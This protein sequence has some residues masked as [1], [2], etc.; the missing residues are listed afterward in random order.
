MVEQPVPKPSDGEILVRLGCCGLCGTDLE[1]IQGSYTASMPI[2]GHEAVGTV[3]ECG[4][5]VTAV[6]VGDRV[7]PHH[8]VPCYECRNCRA[9]STTTCS[10]YRKSNIYP[11]GFSEYFIVPRWNIEHGGLITLPEHVDFESASFIEPLGCVVRSLK[12]TQLHGDED[13]LI[14]GAGPMGL[15]HAQLIKASTHCSVSVY[16]TSTFRSSYSESLGIT[17]AKPNDGAVYD[18][19]VVATGN[20]SAIAYALRKVRRGGKVTVFGVPYKGSALDYDLADLLNNELTLLTSN[21]ADDDDTRTAAKLIS[22]GEIH[23]ERLV[24]HRFSIDNIS[25]AVNTA[26]KAE[27]MKVVVYP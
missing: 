24:T 2:I 4:P 27:A 11:G 21:A 14:V 19:A 26:S 9:G 18:A 17:V 12:R 16:D 7:F 15:L 3:A 5:G 22:S 1:K 10:M 13:V 23:P 20:P 6:S 8:H 25:G